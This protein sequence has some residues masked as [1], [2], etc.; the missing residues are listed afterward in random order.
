VQTCREFGDIQ[1]FI[2]LDNIPQIGPRSFYMQFIELAKICYVRQ[3]REH[4]KCRHIPIEEGICIFSQFLI[5]RS[6]RYHFPN[7]RDIIDDFSLRVKC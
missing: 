1:L 3:I 7:L 4:H 2:Q 6:E 5:D